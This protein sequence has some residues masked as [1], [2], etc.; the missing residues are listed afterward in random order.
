MQ[1][2]CLGDKA[3]ELLVRQCKLEAL[4]ASAGISSGGTLGQKDVCVCVCM[5][6]S[7][8]FEGFA[9]PSICELRDAM[10]AHNGKTNLFPTDPPERKQ[11]HRSEERLLSRLETLGAL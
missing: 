10:E 4:K 11:S 7:S 8:S 9:L 2:F 3:S 5:H 6:S 1:R